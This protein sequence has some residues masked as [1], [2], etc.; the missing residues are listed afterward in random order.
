MRKNG[1]LHDFWLCDVMAP[2]VENH[3]DLFGADVVMKVCENCRSTRDT[4]AFH[5]LNSTKL[6]CETE[7]TQLQ[8][9]D[10]TDIAAA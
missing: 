2:K 6:Y 7:S 5:S 9:Y 8:P 3:T 4:N 1:F 10:L